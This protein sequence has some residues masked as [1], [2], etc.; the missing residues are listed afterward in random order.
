[1]KLHP[2]RVILLSCPPSRV[3]KKHNITYFHPRKISKKKSRKLIITVK[4][5]IKSNGFVQ[6]T[7]S[8]RLPVTSYYRCV[9]IAF[10]L[11]LYLYNMRFLYKL[12][13]AT[14]CYFISSF[15]VTL[16]AGRGSLELRHSTPY[17][18]RSNV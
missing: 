7:Y 1:M 9:I 18:Q 16:Y 12:F 17:F 14:F 4:H 10:I 5:N 2:V 8:R 15:S 3:I 6:Q 13:R 11:I